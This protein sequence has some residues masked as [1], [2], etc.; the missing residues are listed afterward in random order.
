MAQQKEIL[1]KINVDDKSL[2]QLTGELKGVGAEIK[3][4]EDVASGLTLD[5]KFMAADG[6]IKLFTGAVSAAVGAIGL[7]GI[8]SKVFE[9]YERYALSVIAFGRG[10]FDLSEGFKRMR[11]STVLANVALKAND[12]LN[13]TTAATMKVLGLSVNTTS[14]AFRGL[15]AAIATTGIGALVVGL[16]F[17]VEKLISLTNIT[18]AAKNAQDKLN[19]SFDETDKLLNKQISTVDRQLALDKEYAKQKKATTTEELDLELNALNDKIDLFEQERA[20]I[21]NQKIKELEKL[22]NI[23]GFFTKKEKAE[24]Q[25][26]IDSLAEREE[27]LNDKLNDLS[28]QRILK[29]AQTVTS[30]LQETAD[31]TQ[32]IQAFVDKFYTQTADTLEE[33]EGLEVFLV[34]RKYTGLLEEFDGYSAELVGGLQKLGLNRSQL[35]ESQETDLKEIREKYQKIRD[36]LR[37]QAINEEFNRERVYTQTIQDLRTAQEDAEISRIQSR[38]DLTDGNAELRFQLLE[39]QYNQEIGLLD[40]AVIDQQG[41]YQ[42]AYDTGLLNQEEFISLTTQLQRTANEQQLALDDAY[43]TQR[44][45][46]EEQINDAILQSRLS[47]YS[48]IASAFGNLSQLLEQGTE[49]AKAAALAEVAINTAVGFVQGLDIAQKGA[50]GLGPAAPFAFPIFYASQIAAVLGA[51]VQ[52]KNILSTSRSGGTTSGVAETGA[53]GRSFQQPTTVSPGLFDF[54]ALPQGE[55]VNAPR[56]QQSSTPI[57]AYVLAQDVQ[58]ET[59]AR[60]RLNLKRNLT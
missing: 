35:E 39:T 41:I 8:E 14:T 32:Q 58:T 12:V 54:E 31:F 25:A 26:R 43:N 9:E 33:Q 24:A 5:Q 42:N 48:Q 17:L 47:L 16:G 55:I 37:I 34:N 6:A 30:V 18:G 38:L 10:V 13:K 44:L 4:I 50:Q 29:R 7:L 27:E 45:N 28:G 23:R 57:R 40:Q 36:D 51:A 3:S 60:D 56:T 2:E 53:P 15:R 20:N 11:E 19:E 52:A 21:F 22:D 59:E 1:I 49:A 46:T